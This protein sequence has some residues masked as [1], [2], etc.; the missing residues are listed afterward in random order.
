MK[1]KP[2]IV[3]DFDGVIIDGIVEYWSSSRQACLDLIKK[4]PNTKDLPIE[5]PDAFK[6]LRPWVKD[7]WEMV[8]LAAEL[9]RTGID[10][11]NPIKFAAAYEENCQKALQSW[12]WEQEQLQ[13]ALDNVRH[14]AI[15]TNR[16]EWLKS[17]KPFS[18]VVE[19]LNRFKYENTDWA[20]LT[21]KSAE[22]TSELLTSLNLYPTF[23]YGHESGKKADILLKI[24]KNR[25]IKG[26]IEDRK[27]TLQTVL[28]T[29]GLS[30][31]P[32]YLASWGYLKPNDHKNIPLGIRLLKPEDLMSPLAEWP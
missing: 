10:L 26:F 9:I 13:L 4:E 5:V 23:L 7:G 24:S 20:V 16:A 1:T 19:R 21:T 30:T 22:F 31:I 3:F 17:H 29:P 12:G 15:S 2:I 28:N 6:Q 27:A 8:L 18:G 32:C 25:L 14:R 11:N